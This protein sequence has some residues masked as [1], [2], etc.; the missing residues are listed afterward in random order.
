MIDVKHKPIH[1]TSH[2]KFMNHLIKM[3]LP[4]R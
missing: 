4:F 2:T 3:I 1:I